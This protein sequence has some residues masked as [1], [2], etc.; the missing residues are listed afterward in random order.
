MNILVIDSHSFGQSDVISIF[1][2]MG[3]NISLYG[4]PD[5]S[6]HHNDTVHNELYNH[7]LDNDIDLVFSFNY[8]PIVSYVLKDTCVKYISYVYDSPHI[9]IYTCSI[10]F[11][12]NYIFLFDYA[13]YEELKN[14]GI[15]TVYYLPLSVNTKR[16]NQTISYANAIADANGA[17]SNLLDISFVG[18]LYNEHHNL[19]DR[20]IS[21][22]NG[23]YDYVRGYL[24]SIVQAQS[25]VYGYFF[26]DK[27]LDDKILKILDYVYPYDN[28]S[29]S[30]A[31]SAYVYAHYFMARKVTEIER[32]NLLQ[33]VSEAHN[34]SLFTYKD[35]PEL[36]KAQNLGG[37]D[38]YKDM[39]IIFNRSKI[40]L[41][42][43]LK[44]ILTGIPLRCM[45]IMGSG[46]FLLTNYQADLFRHFEAGKHFDYFT[47]ENDLLRK[48][49]YYLSHEDERMT[50]AEAGRKIVEKNHNLEDYLKDMLDF[51]MK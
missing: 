41:N 8:Y 16:L 22:L 5:I 10:I 11:P 51:V 37:V 45:D 18:G 21:K 9:A 20:L 23:N 26:L 44:S 15:T 2:D 28:N 1:K 35:A 7:I 32:I 39:P 30:I 36:P 12:C 27:M 19:Y 38:Y 4:H 47:D 48:V 24:D 40:N 33:K 17:S 25:K 46:G 3:H 34:L 13:V 43:S 42:I 29:D 31:T 6:M 50:I 49:E 14:G